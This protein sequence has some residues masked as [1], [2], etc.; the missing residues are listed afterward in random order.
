MAACAD[1]FEKGKEVARVAV[2]ENE[3]WLGALPKTRDK[4]LIVHAYACAALTMYP[5]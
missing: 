2:A 3:V 5:H 1:G 4:A